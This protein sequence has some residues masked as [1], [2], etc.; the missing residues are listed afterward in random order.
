M[1]MVERY[2]CDTCG[3]LYADAETCERC[4]RQHVKPVEIHGVEHRPMRSVPHYPEKITVLFDDGEKRKYRLL[5][6]E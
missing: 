1:K 4:E 6:G 2:K 5:A 3:T